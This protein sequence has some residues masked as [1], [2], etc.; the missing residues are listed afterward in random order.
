MK[1][2]LKEKGGEVFEK[3]EACEKPYETVGAGP[4]IAA[5]RKT[6]DVDGQWSYRFSLSRRANQGEAEAGDFR[7]EDVLELPKLAEVLAATRQGDDYP[8]V[9]RPVLCHP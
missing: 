3:Q 9:L 5:I 2:D 7:P 6:R 8:A 1:S 4:W